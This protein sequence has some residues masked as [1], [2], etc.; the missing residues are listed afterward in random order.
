MQRG[1]ASARREASSEAEHRKLMT[2]YAQVVCCCDILVSV[3]VS[4]LFAGK[5]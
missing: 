5:L 2:P 4:L 3:R 1:A